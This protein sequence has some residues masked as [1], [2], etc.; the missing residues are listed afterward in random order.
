[1][2]NFK[3]YISSYADLAGYCLMPNHFHLIV[4]FHSFDE[5]QKVFLERK[6]I[7]ESNLDFDKMSNLLSRQF[8][9]FF[10]R[11]AKSF[12]KQEYRRGTLFM[13]SFK[14]KPVESD[15]YL[16]RLIRYV[17]LN[18]VKDKF[19]NLPNEWKYSSYN[20]LVSLK[21]TLLIRDDVME[22]FDTR[23]NFIF[24]HQQNDDGFEY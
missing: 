11:Y 8:S 18:P 24:F 2:L 1:M 6:I 17:N 14:R 12:N 10:N 4:R 13:A 3:D 20:G 7:K 22:L 21:P 5:I 15:Y 9:N 19:V 23:E 16:K